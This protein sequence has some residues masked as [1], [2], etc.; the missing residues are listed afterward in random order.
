MTEASVRDLPLAESGKYVVR[1]MELKGFM[2]VISK[3]AKSWAVQRD[4]WQGPRGNRRLV[5]SVRHTLGRVGAMPL[6]VAREKAF[7]AI[8]LIQQG[9]DPNHQEPVQDLTLGRAWDDYAQA[10]ISRGRQER[11]IED[12]I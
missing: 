8:S 12:Y 11:S 6:R 7:E 4:L 9:I 2:V 1:D 5:K 10:M 3:T